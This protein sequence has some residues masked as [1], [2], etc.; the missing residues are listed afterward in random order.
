MRIM[1]FHCVHCLRELDQSIDER[2]PDHPDGGREIIE[3]FI[4]ESEE[5]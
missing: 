2:C 3:R 1:V 5:Q 4:P